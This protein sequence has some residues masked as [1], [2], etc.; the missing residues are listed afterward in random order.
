[1]TTRQEKFARNLAAGMTQRE[2]YRDAYPASAKWKDE[3]VDCK[4]SLLAKNVKVWQRSEALRKEAEKSVTL[5]REKK[6]ALIEADVEKAVK[7][8]DRYGMIALLKLHND[9]TG[10]N[11]PERKEITLDVLSTIAAKHS[12][13]LE[14]A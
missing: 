9:M 2:A 8:G 14:D 3:S 7:Q 5:T 6:L 13:V 10:D 12:S 4:A 1:M 11:A